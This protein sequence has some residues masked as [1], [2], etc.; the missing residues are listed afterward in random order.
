MT[1][2]AYVNLRNIIVNK[3]PSGSDW[4]DIE[5]DGSPVRQHVRCEGGE[6]YVELNPKRPR[7]PAELRGRVRAVTS[8]EDPYRSEKPF[9]KLVPGKFASRSGKATA[10]VTHYHQ[11]VAVM[12]RVSLD[13]TATSI[14]ALLAM[15]NRLLFGKTQQLAA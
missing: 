3:N 8:S 6:W 9:D 11:G 1:L 15:R 2:R 10:T 5:V 7:L 14:P 13:I 4:I 12:G